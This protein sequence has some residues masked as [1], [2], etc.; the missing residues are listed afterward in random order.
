[1]KN[2]VF[3]RYEHN[4]ILTVDDLSYKAYYIKN[5]GAVKFRDEYLLLVDVFHPEGSI[6]FNIARNRNGYNFRFDPEP[7]DG[8]Q[9]L[10]NTGTADGTIMV[11]RLCDGGFKRLSINSGR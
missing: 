6:V 2:D 4:P 11:S 10:Q 3:K 5:P 9:N 7:E 1:M 8:G